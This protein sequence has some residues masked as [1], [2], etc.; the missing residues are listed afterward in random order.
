M[1]RTNR[2]WRLARRPQGELKPGDLELREE[3]VAAPGQGEVTIRT[4]FLSLDPT[5][6]LWMSDAEQYYPPVEI[7]ATMRGVTLAVVEESR[8]ERFR[9]G[10]IVTP[11][12]GEWALYQTLP[13]R[14]ISRVRRAEGLPL[15]T[16]LNVLGPTGLTAYVG[17]N[18]I[19][20]AKSGETVSISA[21]AG[22]VGSLAGQI[23]RERG[24]RV[25][26]I[27]G[28]REKCDWLV[29]QAG[30]DAAIDYK[31]AD[32]A[33]ELAR[34]CPDGIDAH[35]ENVGGAILDAAIASMRIGGRI[36]LCGLIA[37]YNA[38]GPIPGPR[39]FNLVLMRRL[40]IRGFIVIDHYHR[41]KEAFTEIERMIRAGRLV[42]RDHI[43]EGLE[44]A[45]RALA[46]LFSGGNQGKLMVHVS[47]P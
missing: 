19:A 16:H 8:S 6:R 40:T 11:H 44:E 26:G 22:A 28:G 12:Q 20:G 14:R 7:G 2:T 3:P 24:C 35:F 31:S 32:V 41:A 17:V 46:L 23:A 4:L 39:D 47:D 10:E 5:N 38:D 43:V 30:F 33:G 1:N 13:D 42:W 37:G 15:S 21:A 29:N 18:D 25:I 9:P 34:L 36:A 45:P 27:A